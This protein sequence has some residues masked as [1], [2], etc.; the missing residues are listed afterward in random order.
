MRL[1]YVFL[2]H[3]LH[4]IAL[5]CVFIRIFQKPARDRI[6]HL[7]SAF[8]RVNYDVLWHVLHDCGV[9]RQMLQ[10]SFVS[11]EAE[12]PWGLRPRHYDQRRIVMFLYGMFCRVMTRRS[13]TLQGRKMADRALIVKRD[14]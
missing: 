14:Q 9:L 13:K 1:R 6:E 5:L 11:G 3:L 10:A 12:E 7:V 8:A 2:W 4:C